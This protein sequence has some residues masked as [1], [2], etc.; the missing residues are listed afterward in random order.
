MAELVSQRVAQSWCWLVGARSQAVWGGPE[1]GGV[2][3]PE[4]V[5]GALEALLV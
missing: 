4:E 5:G 3:G 2:Q 1:E